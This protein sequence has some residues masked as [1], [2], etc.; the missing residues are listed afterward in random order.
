MFEKVNPAHPDKIADRIA[1]AIVDLAY[2]KKEDPKVAAEVLIGH[3]KC[4]IINET[5][6]HLTTEE[7]SKAVW[8]ITGDR[9]MAVDYT[10]RKQDAHLAENQAHEIRCGDNGI[11]AGEPRQPEERRLAEI[12]RRLYEQSGR[13]D[14][15]YIIDGNELIICQSNM[16]TSEIRRKY[17]DAKINPIGDWTGGTDVDSGA[18]NRKLGSDMGRAATGGGLHGKDLSKADVSVNIFAH[19]AAQKAGRRVEMKCAIGDR[20]VCGIPYGIIVA[21][22][23][24]YIDALGGFER[25]AEWGLVR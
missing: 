8:R 13:S 24:E 4:T 15:K 19:I 3:G 16:G 21:T 11:F 20:E 1:G 7:I 17:P 18:T 6:T 10:E 2:S 14:G 12:A 22:A 5:D 23:K 9:D 25:F